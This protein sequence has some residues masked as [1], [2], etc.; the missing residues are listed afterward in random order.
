[1]R[2]PVGLV[3]VESEARHIGVRA[4]ETLADQAGAGGDVR[5]LVGI[6]E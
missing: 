1:M 2:P 5:E 6:G 3:V 4:V